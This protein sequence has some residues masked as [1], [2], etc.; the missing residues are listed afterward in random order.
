MKIKIG[1]LPQVFGASG[2]GSFKNSKNITNYATFKEAYSDLLKNK[3]DVLVTS[4]KLLNI[5]Q[6]YVSNFMLSMA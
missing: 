4:P 1:I 2:Y 6:A 3:I 5:D